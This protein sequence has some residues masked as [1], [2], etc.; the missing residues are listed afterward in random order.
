MIIVYVIQSL[1]KNYRYIGITNNLER[2]FKQHNNGYNK[3]TKSYRPFQLI[4]TEEFK[5]YKEAR[6]REIFLKSG[7]GRKFLD[8]L[9]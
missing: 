7:A 1:N 8:E 4:F 5:N 9:E 2:R 3:N 6:K